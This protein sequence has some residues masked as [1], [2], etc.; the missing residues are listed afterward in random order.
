M[1][2]QNAT[3][4]ATHMAR[5]LGKSIGSPTMVRESGGMYAQPVY[6]SAGMNLAASHAGARGVPVQSGELTVTAKVEMYFEYAR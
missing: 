5:A 1:A 4:K 6:E 2:I 3:G